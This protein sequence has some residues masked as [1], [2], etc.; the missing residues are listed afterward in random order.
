[1]TRI[2][3]AECGTWPLRETN[4]RDR[5]KRQQQYE[6]SWVNIVDQ[7]MSLIINEQIREGSMDKAT[8]DKYVSD[9]YFGEIAWYDAKS[10]RNQ[11]WYRTL[12]WGL[13]LLSA[14][15]PV[16]IALAQKTNS[17]PW[18]NMVPLMTSVAVAILATSLKT[19]KF[20]ENW[21]RWGIYFTQVGPIYCGRPRQ[22]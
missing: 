7:R 9:R 8:F 6:V 5:I 2:E 15:T 13:I 10:I 19:F 14:S 4:L 17:V 12:Q 16:L 18:L 11:I 21:I 20:E 3:L 1:V 22:F